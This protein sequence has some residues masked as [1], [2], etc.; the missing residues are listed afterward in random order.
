MFFK[1]A[2][3]FAVALAVLA[4]SPAAVQAAGIDQTSV[5]VAY[6]DLDLSTEEGQAVLQSRLDHAAS[7]VCGGNEVHRALGEDIL[8]K[9]CRADTVSDSLAAV[10]KAN[11]S[12]ST[13][14]MK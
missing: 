7:V 10:H 14:A 2:A 4:V 11:V 5:R 12:I 8:F 1:S 13:V 6:G 9:A 3:P